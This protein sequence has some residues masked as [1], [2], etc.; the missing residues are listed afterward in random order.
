[1]TDRSKPTWRLPWVSVLALV[2]LAYNI[3]THN[4]FHDDAAL[5]F[6]KELSDQER[7]QP[8][9]RQATEPQTIVL[10]IIDPQQF[11]SEIGDPRT[12]AF[13][14]SYREPCEITI[15]AGWIIVA[16]PS[17]GI[18]FWADDRNAVILAHEILHCIRGSWHPPWPPEKE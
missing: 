1:M 6:P 15:P 5:R 8:F 2:W 7:V 11:K 13:S 9:I 10:R 4:P 16:I 3:G 17:R 18:A 12:A 14:K